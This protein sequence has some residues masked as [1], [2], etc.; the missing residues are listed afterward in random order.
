MPYKKGEKAVLAECEVLQLSIRSSG[1]RIKVICNL[2][3]QDEIQV[4]INIHL[5]RLDK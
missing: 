3:F 4:H 2:N 5:K 1:I